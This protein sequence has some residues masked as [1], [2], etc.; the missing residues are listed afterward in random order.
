VGQS[1]NPY[2]SSYPLWYVPQGFLLPY[3]RDGIRFLDCPL[4]AGELGILL[5]LSLLDEPDPDGQTHVSQ[6][7]DTVPL[8]GLYTPEEKKGVPV[9]SRL[10]METLMPYKREDIL[11][12]PSYPTLS[13]ISVGLA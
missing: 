10:G 3:R 9:P 4:P 13:H 1:L 6:L 12:K 11:K 8:G 2:P 7:G 5:T